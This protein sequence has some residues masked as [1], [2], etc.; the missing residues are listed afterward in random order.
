MNCLCFTFL[1]FYHDLKKWS[2]CPSWHVCALCSLTGMAAAVAKLPVKKKKEEADENH[3]MQWASAIQAKHTLLQSEKVISPVKNSFFL[4]LFS[5]QGYSVQ[6][7]LPGEE[8]IIN[9]M[10]AWYSKSQNHRLEDSTLVL[11]SCDLTR[12]DQHPAD[13]NECFRT[14][15]FH[16]RPSWAPNTSVNLC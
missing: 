10:M 1:G 3:V 15:V 11:L 12:T 14:L 6:H 2:N 7:C 4:I 5:N 9:Q 13:S 16:P 8:K